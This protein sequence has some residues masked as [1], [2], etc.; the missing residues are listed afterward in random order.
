MP[1]NTTE[2]VAPATDAVIVSLTKEPAPER[3]VTSEPLTVDPTLEPAPN[4]A[5]ASKI[6]TQVIA[7]AEQVKAAIDGGDKRRQIR[8]GYHLLRQAEAEFK[9][10]H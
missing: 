8:A 3:N 7:L 6:V 1:K 10:G 9:R 5:S 2:V 4:P